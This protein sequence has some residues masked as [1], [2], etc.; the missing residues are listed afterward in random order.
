MPA[1]PSRARANAVRRFM[2]LSNRGQ[3][4]VLVSQS[5]YRG[6]IQTDTTRIFLPLQISHCAHLSAIHCGIVKFRCCGNPIS[7]LEPNREMEVSMPKAS[8]DKLDRQIIAALA[9]DGR[10]PYRELARA[11]DVSEG[12]NPALACR[13]CR[14]TG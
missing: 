11:L 8:L 2:S 10:R 1:D 6:F 4:R 9:R 5:L 7:R 3:E 12:H 13:A 14:K